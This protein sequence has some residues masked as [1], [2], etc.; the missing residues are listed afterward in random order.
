[1][2]DRTMINFGIGLFVF[3]VSVFF[4]PYTPIF[5]ILQLNVPIG[6]IY[7]ICAISVIGGIIMIVK[8]NRRHI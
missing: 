7:S 6:L 4:L 2:V 3:G 5:S 8:G 1:M